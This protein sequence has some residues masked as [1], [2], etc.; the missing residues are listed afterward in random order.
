MNGKIPEDLSDVEGVPASQETNPPDLVNLATI[1]WIVVVKSSYSLWYS[2]RDSLF[3]RPTPS[4]EPAPGFSPDEPPQP[5]D[6]QPAAHTLS[7]PAPEEKTAAGRAQAADS[8][9]LA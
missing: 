7:G 6:L 2:L 3:P 4:L 9:T 8:S 5:M 1:F